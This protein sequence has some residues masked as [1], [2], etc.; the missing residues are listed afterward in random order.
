MKVQWLNEDVDDDG[1]WAYQLRFAMWNNS[2]K[3]K[4]LV[5][6]PPFF[7]L[8][9]KVAKA[10][11]HH[12]PNWSNYV[13]FSLFC[14]RRHRRLCHR[15]ASHL[16]KF[17]EMTVINANSISNIFL[18]LMGKFRPVE[19]DCAAVRQTL[20]KC[21]I[22]I[23]RTRLW[24][25]IDFIDKIEHVFV[26]VLSA[27]EIDRDKQ[28]LSRDARR[29]HHHIP[30]Y[31]HLTNWGFN[32]VITPTVYYGCTHSLAT[33]SSTNTRWP[34]LPSDDEHASREKRNVTNNDN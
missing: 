6:G 18:Q 23:V 20:V 24:Q 14:R 21:K 27:K 8:F 10:T 1:R 4:Q 33:A 15:S 31:I 5:R 3:E 16:V 30:L 13:C 32:I 26:L 9:S 34:L 11:R 12:T 25:L 7:S 19:I 29:V 28:S 2:T 17:E 22:E